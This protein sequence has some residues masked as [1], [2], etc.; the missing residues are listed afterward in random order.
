MNDV[1]TKSDQ[2]ANKPYLTEQV[3]DALEQG[4]VIPI[5]IDS[6]EIHGFRDLLIEILVPVVPDD[7]FGFVLEDRKQKRNVIKGQVIHRHGIDECE[8]ERPMHLE[9]GSH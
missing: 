4:A 3:T 1:R 5:S 7:R 9:H 2:F 8:S 6:G